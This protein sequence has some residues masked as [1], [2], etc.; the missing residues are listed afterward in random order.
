MLF[1]FLLGKRTLYDK[2]IRVPAEPKESPDGCRTNI[3][4]DRLILLNC[5]IC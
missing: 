2:H 4:E 3:N 1:H 5:Q